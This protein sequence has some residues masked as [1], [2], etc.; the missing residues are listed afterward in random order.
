MNIKS[1]NHKEHKELHKDHK[2]KASEFLYELCENLR[3]LCVLKKCLINKFL[4]RHNHVFGS[5]Q[6]VDT[7]FA[8]CELVIIIFFNFNNTIP[9]T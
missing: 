9:H 2:D 8:A 1:N 6:E 3:D 5:I 4:F 7:H